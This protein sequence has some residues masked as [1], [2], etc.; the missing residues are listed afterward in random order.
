MCVK[1]GTPTL[2]KVRTAAAFNRQRFGLFEQSEPDIEPATIC[3]QFNENSSN[4][5]TVQRAESWHKIGGA[6]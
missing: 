5:S 2:L 1:P 6:S 3:H 4:F